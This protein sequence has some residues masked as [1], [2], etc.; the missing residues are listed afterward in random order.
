MTLFYDGGYIC[1]D[2]APAIETM[3]SL[4]FLLFSL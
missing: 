3:L 2:Y 4:D 1:I